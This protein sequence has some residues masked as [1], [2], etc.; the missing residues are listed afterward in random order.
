MSSVLPTPAWGLLCFTLALQHSCTQPIAQKKSAL[1]DLDT[2]EHILREAWANREVHEKVHGVDISKEF[3]RARAKLQTS[4]TPSESL[5][6]LRQLTA[7]MR[8]G[9]MTIE[10]PHMAP[11]KSAGS[12][13]GFADSTQGWVVSWVDSSRYD[14]TSD[15]K[16]RRLLSVDGASVKDYVDGFFLLPSSSGPQQAHVARQALSWQQ[17]LADE[18]YAPKFIALEGIPNSI[19]LAWDNPV[20]T[21]PVSTNPVEPNCVQGRIVA[22]SIGVIVVN[23]FGC[24]GRQDSPAYAKQLSNALQTVAGAQKI[25][26]DLRHNGGGFTEPVERLADVFEESVAVWYH[27]VRPSPGVFQNEAQ[28]KD[29]DYARRKQWDPPAKL[30]GPHAILIGPGCFSWCDMAVTAWSQKGAKLFGTP[31][32]AGTGDPLSYRLPYFGAQVRVPSLKVYGPGSSEQIEAHPVVPDFPVKPSP[33]DIIAG[34]D[35][36]LDAATQWLLGHQK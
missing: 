26:L 10:Y 36:V 2:L 11:R 21:N 8:D 27:G 18:D 7:K 29:F 16:G 30:P 25:I 15:W 20:N 22:E 1:A 33:E 31:T 24:E 32:G 6:V 9:H 34:R 14:D 13:I 28:S 23:T 35:T 3:A 5:Q 17:R 19:A 4:Q 12:G